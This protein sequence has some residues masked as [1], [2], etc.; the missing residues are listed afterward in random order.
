VAFMAAMLNS[1]LSSTD[2]IA[3]YIGECR[4]M[5]IEVLGPDINESGYYFTVVGEQIQYGLGAVKGVGQGA[6]EEILAAR[7][8]AGRF[9]S[10]THLATELDLR[11]V[12][13]KVFECL[14]KAGAFDGLGVHRAALWS[15][16]DALLDYAQRR[17]Q[18]RDAGQVNLFGALVPAMEPTPDPKVKPWPERE[19]MRYEKEALGLF[20]TGNPLTDHQEALERFITHTTAS[21]REAPPDGT[22]TVGGMVAGFS[23]VKI[24]SGA[25]AGRFMGRFTLEDLEGSLPVTLFANQLQQ[26]GHLLADEALVL[27][28]GQVRE[29]GPDFELTVEEITPLDKV[30][31][32]PL[33]GVELRIAPSISQS[34]MLELRDLLTQHPGDVPV[35]LE[36]QLP[37]R[38]VRI[39]TQE[40]LKVELSPEL[41]AS[42]RGLLG[43]EGVRERYQTAGV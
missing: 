9:R 13:R 35:T 7:R 27:I 33:A 43:E 39:A 3:K 17:R 16:L 15:G 32:R 8:R 2:A 36:M 26:F 37:D 19:R 29:R 20:L 11:G 38:T 14:V 31:A 41:A 30:A 34:R 42:L 4:N 6:V 28:K 1:E 24:K 22:V 40:N 21:L 10:L 23:R 5:G 12:N 18:E 25:N